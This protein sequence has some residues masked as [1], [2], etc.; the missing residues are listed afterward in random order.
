MARRHV[1]TIVCSEESTISLSST[2]V[3]Y[4]F[5][6][7]QESSEKIEIVPPQPHPTLDNIIA[8]CRGTDHV[9]CLNNEGKVFTFGLDTDGRLGKPFSLF[10]I[11]KIIYDNLIYGVVPP[12][13]TQC[14]FELRDIPTIVQISCGDR[15]TVCLGEN[16]HLYSF[17]NN[18]YGPWY[19]K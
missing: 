2:G 14:P 11:V 17:G 6:R 16:G 8:V 5:G 12:L 10:T 9:V 4:C 13:Y 15:F 18:E 3:P 1:S 19:W 7:F